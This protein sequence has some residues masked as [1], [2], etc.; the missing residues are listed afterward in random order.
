[1]SNYDGS[2]LK[3]DRKEITVRHGY[4]R[5]DE[6]YVV[7]KHKLDR[8]GIVKLEYYTPVNVTNTTALRIE[9][10]PRYQLN[11]LF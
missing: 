3:T 9:V 8:N 10:L 2:P 6:V 11:C 4:S 1:M 5:A 7:E